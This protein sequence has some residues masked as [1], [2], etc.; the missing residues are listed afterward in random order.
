MST[1][2]LAEHD[3]LTG[4][5]GTVQS[6]DV[7]RALQLRPRMNLIFPPKRY[8]DAL[9]GN[10]GITHTVFAFWR[11]VVAYEKLDHSSMEAVT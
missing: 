1:K 10:H 4:A 5:F 8:K 9:G 7:F 2:L 3:R 11:V 6:G